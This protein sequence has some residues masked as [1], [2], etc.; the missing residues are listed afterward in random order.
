[1]SSDYIRALQDAL[2]ALTRRLNALGASLIGM[3]T[4]QSTGTNNTNLISG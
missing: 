2:A 1:M 3:D 4:I